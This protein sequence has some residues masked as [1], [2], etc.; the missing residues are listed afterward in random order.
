ML[1]R[2]RDV[3]AKGDQEQNR[4]ADH[5]APPDAHDVTKVCGTSR[6]KSDHDARL[7]ATSSRSISAARMLALGT[8]D[9]MARSSNQ[10]VTF[11]EYA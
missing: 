9:L 10:A 4:K 5:P 1:Q 6:T 7:R 8:L 11:G 2:S 3:D